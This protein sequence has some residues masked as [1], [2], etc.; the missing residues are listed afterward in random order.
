MLG[1]RR[2]IRLSYGTGAPAEGRGRLEA[3]YQSD[4]VIA[5]LPNRPGVVGYLAGEWSRSH[6]HKGIYSDNHEYPTDWSA[7][8]NLATV[9]LARHGQE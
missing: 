9:I 7:E 3:P 4:R 2:S 5:S 1:N 8:L 6:S